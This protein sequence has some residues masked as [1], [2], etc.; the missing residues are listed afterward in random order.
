M[1]LTFF[2][3]LP[4]H[5]NPFILNDSNSKISDFLSQV[6]IQYILLAIKQQKHATTPV[7]S[8]V[9]H[10]SWVKYR[11]DQDIKIDI[12]FLTVIFFLSFKKLFKGITPPNYC[13]STSI[14][15]VCSG[16]SIRYNDVIYS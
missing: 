1:N 14:N 8:L 4:S 7:I 9:Y 2:F 16:F 11:L 5:K 15:Q 3:F 12:F 13:I 10:H 6:Y